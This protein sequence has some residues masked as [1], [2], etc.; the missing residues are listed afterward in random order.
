MNKPDMKNESPAIRNFSRRQALGLIGA[1]AATS[2]VGSAAEQPALSEQGGAPVQNAKSRLVSFDAKP[3][4]L[5][6][7]T[8]KTA[9]IVV[10]MQ[11]DFGAKGGMMDLAGLD[12]SGIRKAIDPIAK[13]LASARQAGIKV[14]YLKMA[15]LPGLSDMG[16]ADSPNRVRHLARGVGKTVHAPDGRE[17]RILIRDTWN[18]DILDELKPQPGDVVMYKHRF[19]G[20]Y[21]TDLDTTLKKLGSKH[22]IITGCTTSVCVESTVRDAMFRDYSCVVLQDC[23]NQPAVGNSLVGSNHDASL[24]VVEAVFGWVSNSDQF[25]KAL[26]VQPIAAA[27]A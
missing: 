19:S 9:V 5:A 11:N 23:V 24:V 18:T 22:L 14:I 20:F 27:Q 17:S 4:P 21:Q 13:V 16:A 15:F 1:T 3:N 7:D 26:Q 8:A 10:D 25:V 6:I 12:I 2:L